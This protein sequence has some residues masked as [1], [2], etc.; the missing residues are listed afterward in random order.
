M[1]WKAALRWRAGAGCIP[2]RVMDLV[3]AE[4][5]RVGRLLAWKGLMLRALRLR[6]S[7][8][9]AGLVP[10]VSTNP[11]PGISSNILNANTMYFICKISSSRKQD[12]SFA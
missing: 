8:S 6:Q 11:K 7:Y 3:P 4:R 2:S 12:Q 9:G 1:H 10:G 5:K